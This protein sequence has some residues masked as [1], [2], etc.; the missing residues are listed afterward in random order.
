MAKYSW[1]SAGNSKAAAIETH[2]ATAYQWKGFTTYDD[3]KAVT[4]S[5]DDDQLDWY[6]QDTGAAETMTVDGQVLSVQWSGTIKTNFTD[7]DGAAHSEE[8]IYTYTSNGYYLIPKAGSSFDEGSTI[9]CFS[10]GWEDTD[11]IDYDEVIC[12][13][14][15]CR[16]ETAQGPVA[17]GDL[18]PGDLLQTPDT[19]LQPLRWIGR[20]DLPGLKR[21]A[22]GLHP[23][24]IRKDAFGPGQPARDI[25]VSP[26]HRFCFANAALMFHADEVLAPAK[27]LIDG[28]RVTEDRSAQGI[29]YIH[30]LLDRH[31]IL[32]C[33]GVATESFQPALRTM[34]LMAPRARADLARVLGG[35]L[36]RYAPARAALRPWEAPLLSRVS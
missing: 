8:M 6:G 9:K 3:A 11:G 12:F 27:G 4:I 7:S 21:I 29:S 33:E 17:A 20:S 36:G 26:Q 15:A 18:R 10:G 14:P 28:A 23:V 2:E 35:D 34:A 16:I 31:E 5:D 1:G 19:G 30:L 32:F 13:T 25:L 24:R 22:A